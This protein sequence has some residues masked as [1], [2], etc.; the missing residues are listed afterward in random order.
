MKADPGKLGRIF[1]HITD[2]NGKRVSVV[3][4][5][6]SRYDGK[7]RLDE[8]LVAGFELLAN[9]PPNKQCVVRVEPLTRVKSI[10]GSTI[11]VDLSPMLDVWSQGRE[12]VSQQM[13]F[14]SSV[15]QVKL[16]KAKTKDKE[17]AEKEAADDTGGEGGRCSRDCYER[18]HY[19]A[20]DK[21]IKSV[22]LHANS[23]TI[24]VEERASNP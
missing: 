7:L 11:Q 17:A 4:H 24:W 12:G 21:I 8:G 19:L 13:F 14:S 9:E 5:D 22:R 6:G 2:L 1:E 20:P 3:D 10:T 15:D 23:V 18:T 16:H